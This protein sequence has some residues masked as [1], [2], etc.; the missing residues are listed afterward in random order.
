MLSGRAHEAGKGTVRVL[1]SIEQMAI[2]R[3]CSAT[4][5]NSL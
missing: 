1:P 4:Y 3:Y 5:Q 2:G